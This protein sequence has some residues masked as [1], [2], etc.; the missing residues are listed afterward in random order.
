MHI[1]DLLIPERIRFGVRARSRKRVLEVAAR[2]LHQ[3]EEDLDERIIYSGLCG[4]ERIGSTALG[5]GVALPHCRLSG[6]PAAAG[7]L[8]TLADPVDFDAPD[9]GPIDLVFALM[10]PDNHENE[11]LK[12]L[13]MLAETF[14][15]EANRA[16][17]RGADSPFEVLDLLESWETRHVA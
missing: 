14:R 3:G 9:G 5:H 2:Q 17:L 11:H 6:L 16:A 4:R 13:A 7:T 15:I 12:L 1:S 10:V 8:I